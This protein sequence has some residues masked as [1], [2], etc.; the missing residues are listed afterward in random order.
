MLAI[1]NYIENVKCESFKDFDTGR[2]RIRPLP[3]QG[4]STNLMI[5][6]RKEFRETNKFP[7]GTQ[8]ST[9]NVKVCQKEVGR[10]YLRAEKQMLYKIE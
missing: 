8:F 7:L 4:I 6:C 9:T 10:I 5:E 2:I 3:N 1:D